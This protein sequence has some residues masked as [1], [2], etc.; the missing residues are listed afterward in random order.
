MQ[1]RGDIMAYIKKTISFFN[2]SIEL[3]AAV[4]ALGLALAAGLALLL[5]A[6]V[7]SE[8][9][10]GGIADKVIR[11]HILANSDA[12]RDQALKLIVRDKVLAELSGVLT[13]NET[14]SEAREKL[15]TLLPE[16]EG[17]AA[18]A[19][20][21]QGSD[22]PVRAYLTNSYFPTRTYQQAAF[23]AG[24]Y[25]ALRLEI[26]AGEGRNWW[27]VMFP[28]L[29]FVDAAAGYEEKEDKEE[30]QRILKDRLTAE[31]YDLVTMS[32][33]E[34]VEIRFKIVEIWQGIKNWFR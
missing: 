2:R 5:S 9:I 13:G 22:Y 17:W 20:A 21:G 33:G 15:R 24:M 8:R 3:R 32:G 11:F 28:P 6:A 16:I 26:G 25:E 31:G 30:G 4:I 12:D 27:C 7:Y 23:P 34:K 29:C 10:Q 14:G 1:A 18:E 19:L